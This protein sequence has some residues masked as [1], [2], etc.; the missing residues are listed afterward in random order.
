MEILHTDILIAGAG[1]AGMCAALALAHRGYSILLVD[2]AQPTKRADE[3][4]TAILAPGHDLLLATGVWEKLAPHARELQAMRII[5]TASTPVSRD[6]LAQDMD[7]DAFGWNLPNMALRNALFEAVA[8]RPN[9]TCRFG[10][11]V[12]GFTGRSAHARLTLS[13]GE[14]VQAMLALACDGRDSALRGLAGI[15]M[16]RHDI[17]QKALVFSVAH[18]EPHNYVSTEV[19]KSGGPFTLVPLPDRD[20][21]PQSAVVWMTSGTEISRL[22]ALDDTALAREATTRCNAIL[23]PLK[24]TTP[25]QIWPI[26]TQ[27][28]ERFFD[29]RLALAAE[30]AHVVPPI[31]A[32]GLNMSLADIAWLHAHL[33][34]D[35]GEAR[36][37]AAYD[38]TR[39]QDV[40]M[41]Q[42]GIDMLN[43]ASATANAPMQK[44]RKAGLGALH[45]IA[46]LRQ[47]VMRLGLGG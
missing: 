16:R 46:P 20:G 21:S 33:G 39:R 18:P 11:S 32:Q 25:R 17:G 26:I 27:T 3:R 44:L 47:A 40:R 23:G 38:Q 7:R 6:F 45:D 9:I 29:Q 8:A 31:G 34:D 1:P 12:T 24:L 10:T 43:R 22:A 5:D 37:L 28:A 19:H 4:S 42:F 36:V 2:P 41:R 15:E 30:A 14:T 13:S 35:P